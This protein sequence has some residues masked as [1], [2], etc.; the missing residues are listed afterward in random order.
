MNEVHEGGSD[1]A[2]F[3]SPG[4]H[5]L[6]PEAMEMEKENMASLPAKTA[7][8]L[9]LQGRERAKLAGVKA[10]SCFNDR[11]VVLETAEGELALLGENLHI[12]QLNLEEGCLDVT[13][14]ISG[15][16]YSE[17]SAPRERKGLF[18]RHRK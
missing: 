1:A 15:L 2:F 18:A 14:S 3:F 17:R 7:H 13:G 9:T 11:E 5:T 16:E 8:S 12:E 4:Q 6:Y 10:V